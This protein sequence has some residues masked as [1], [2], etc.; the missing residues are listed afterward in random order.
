MTT[1][2]F[3]PI[4]PASM[5][6][7]G[8]VPPKERIVQRLCAWIA[9]G[10]L[11]PGTPLPPVREAAL[12]FHVDKGTMARAYQILRETGRVQIVGRGTRARLT[13]GP[14]DTTGGLLELITTTAP[15]LLDQRPDSTGWSINRERGVLAAAHAAGWSV[16]LRPPG[17]STGPRPSGVIVTSP[18]PDLDRRLE[19][20]RA[21]GIP[22]VVYGD[23]IDGDHR[24]R[25][26][27]DHADGARQLVR[28]L[29][30]SGR[31][32]I[33]FHCPSADLP[34]IRERHRGYLAGMADAGLTPRP[35]LVIDTLPDNL[36]AVQ[37]FVGGLAPAL[38]GNE[39]PDAI[40]GISDGEAMHLATA[41]LRLGWPV[42]DRLC[43]TGFDHYWPTSQSR[44]PGT[45]PPWATM[46]KH[47]QDI[48]HALVQVLL[49]RLRQGP[50]AAPIIR[51]MTP[52]MVGGDATPAA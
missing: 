26:M 11:P 13:V 21:Q 1:G 35:P 14:T 10:T 18:V 33:L 17:R 36:Q 23:L 52:R 44:H 28:R 51:R 39:P 4:D 38:L 31:Q 47:N 7:A 37:L 12:Q 42:H 30:Q 34:W 48:G 41:A 3:P 43:I 49:E 2:P 24:D 32:R 40:L 9:D 50:G 27:T 25:V 16:L 15:E 22:V 45:V 46:E 6:R 19:D 5:G 29:A 20:L 8:S